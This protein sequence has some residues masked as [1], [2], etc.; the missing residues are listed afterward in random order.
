MALENLFS[1]KTPLREGFEWTGKS[2]ACVGLIGTGWQ[3][4]KLQLAVNSVIGGFVLTQG[5]IPFV[6]LSRR[7]GADRRCNFKAVREL[8]EYGT[9]WIAAL[10]NQDLTGAGTIYECL[11][12][13][14][15]ADGRLNNDDVAEELLEVVKQDLQAMLLPLEAAAALTPVLGL[16]GSILGVIGILTA[17]GDDAAVQAA[18]TTMFSSTGVGCAASF[19]LGGLAAIGQ[20]AINR[21]MS[22]VKLVVQLLLDGKIDDSDDQDFEDGD[23]L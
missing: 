21:H 7:I 5:V 22:A 14:Q 9:D 1:G 11:A 19:L 4:G 20:S 12:A 6:R 17:G 2:V 23:L 15:A 10:V 16:G 8:Q 13:I 18:M 3:L